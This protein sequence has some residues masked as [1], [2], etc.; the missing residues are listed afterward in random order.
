MAMRCRLTLLGL[1]A[2][3]APAGLVLIHGQGHAQERKIARERLAAEAFDS[4]RK[5]AVVIGIDEYLDPNIVALKY[6]VADARLVAQQL[7]ERCGYDEQRVLLLTDDQPKTH[8]R[9]LAINLRNQAR[10]WLM[11]AAEGDTVL[12]FFSGHGFLDD[13]GQGFL[14]PA[15][16]QRDNLGLTALRT[17]E[18]RDMLRQCKAT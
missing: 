1:F 16:C 15:D 9:P 3:L 6:A 2:A 8:L 12:I 10:N 14:A 18:L 5:W 11:N 17:D 7:A 13:R 4:G